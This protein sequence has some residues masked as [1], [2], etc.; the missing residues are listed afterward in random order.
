MIFDFTPFWI[1]GQPSQ[2]FHISKFKTEILVHS[3]FYLVSSLLALETTELVSGLVTQMALKLINNHLISV[4]KRDK[5]KA[6]FLFH[7]TITTNI[8]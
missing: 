5:S 1:H 8:F 2:L 7:V 6:T 3:H 4:S